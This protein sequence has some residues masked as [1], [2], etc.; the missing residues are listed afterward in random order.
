MLSNCS[1]WILMRV[2]L[3]SAKHCRWEW[4][5]ISSRED[6]VEWLEGQVLA[7]LAMAAAEAEQHIA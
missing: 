2:L 3:S 7:A 6:K 4:H 5:A 1:V